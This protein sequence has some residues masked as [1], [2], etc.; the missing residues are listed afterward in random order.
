MPVAA[1]ER[2]FLIVSERECLAI[3]GR[4]ICSGHFSRTDVPGVIE[5]RPRINYARR[6]RGPITIRSDRPSYTMF[7]SFADPPSGV[8]T[9]AQTLESLKRD[10]T[11]NL[12]RLFALPAWKFHGGSRQLRFHFYCL[13][14]SRCFRI[15]HGR[16]LHFRR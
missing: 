10:S 3:V 15:I 13:L 4:Q 14:P 12:A 16:F 2:R 5:K 9:L 6:V 1:R 7:L 11:E 8:V